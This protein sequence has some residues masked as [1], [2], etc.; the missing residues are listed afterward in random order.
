VVAVA[1][2]WVTVVGAVEVVPVDAAVEDVELAALVAAVPVV[3]AAAVPGIVI[4]PTTA[5]RAVATLAAAAEPTVRRRRRR[6]PASRLLGVGVASVSFMSLRMRG[7]A[8]DFVR[9]GL[10]SAVTRCRQVVPIEPVSRDICG[11]VVPL[12]P[13]SGL[14]RRLRRSL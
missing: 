8:E 10:E 4:A 3:L 14:G 11:Q 12:V 13:I 2:A 5:K 1:G 7:A 6:R 9:V